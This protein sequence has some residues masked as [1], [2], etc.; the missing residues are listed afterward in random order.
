MIMLAKEKKKK[1]IDVCTSNSVS[2]VY[3]YF[4]R[5]EIERI[6]FDE[7]IASSASSSSSSAVSKQPSIR[8]KRKDSSS[9]SESE[10]NKKS[11]QD[12]AP[13]DQISKR[14]VVN[15]NEPIS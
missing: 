3:I 4:Q 11:E 5:K 12:Q 13:N 2:K 1:K 6:I 9:D 15:H 14:I 8:E 10:T 7:I